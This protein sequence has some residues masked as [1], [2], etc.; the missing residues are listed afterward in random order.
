MSKQVAVSFEDNL[1]KVVYASSD[2]GR[3]VV[4]KT[5]SFKDEEFDSFLKTTRL[6]DLTVV[7]N[8][9]RFYSDIL[10]CSPCKTRLS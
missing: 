8:F 9:K 5:T 3:T 1:V 4:Q 6:P 10:Y 2:K 7:C